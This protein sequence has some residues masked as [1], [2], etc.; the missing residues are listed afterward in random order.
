MR[1]PYG[2]I[3]NT[4][5][6]MPVE[7]HTANAGGREVWS[8]PQKLAR[9]SLAVVRDTLLGTLDVGPVAVP[10]PGEARWRQAV[11]GG[12]VSFLANGRCGGPLPPLRPGFRSLP[13]IRLGEIMSV[14]ARRR[15]WTLEQKLASVAAVSDRGG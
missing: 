4:I 5:H 3:G 15:R 10:H 12:R 2:V 11:R 6:A 9:P 13:D 14:V 8:F 7:S 1:P